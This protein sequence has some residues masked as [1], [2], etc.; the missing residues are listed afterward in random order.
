MTN[1]VN[2]SDAR[3][4]GFRMPAEWV[5]HERTWMMWPTRKECWPDMALTKKSFVGVAQAIIKFEPVTVVV[6]PE[7]ENEARTALPDQVE[8]LITKIDDSWCRD[9]GPNFLLNDQG[10]LAGS[11][12]EFNAWGEN[13]FP[14]DN[15]NKVGATILETQGAHNFVSELVAEGGG[16]LVD[17]EGTIIT[18]ESCF[19]H[20]NRNP[21]WT[22]GEVE[23]EL[24]RTLGGE[25]VIWLPGNDA[26]VETNG[27]VDGI[28]QYV[29]PGVVLMET[30]FD[31]EHPW[32]EDLKLNIEAMQ[33]Q[34]D[35]KGRTIDIVLIEDAHGCKV[36]GERYCASYL[37]SYLVNGAVIM[38]KYGV[39]ADERAQAVYRRLFP[40][41]EIVAIDIDGV[42]M[43]GG[44]IHC[45]TQQQPKAGIKA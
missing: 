42:A 41:R 25:K 14:Y 10:E 1:T 36:T 33:G 43:G 32:Y 12:F 37:N 28:G 15:D 9:A 4:Q 18:T 35:A 26:E 8:L 3:A 44:G 30:T 24:L 38:P 39:P 7:D 2:K 17:G 13:Y 29:R 5:E 34:T 20:T 31:M 6:S 40:N 45:I 16:V 23:E 11:T 21:G 27:H 19:L 22:K